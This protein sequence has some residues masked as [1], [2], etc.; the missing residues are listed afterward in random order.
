[1][2][3]FYKGLME[4]VKSEENKAIEELEEEYS[5]RKR[6]V[7]QKF[8]NRRRAV[9]AACPHDRTHTRGCFDYH[10]MVDWED[11]YCS[12]CGKLLSGV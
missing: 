3:D 5:A 1:M 4:E 2:S 6:E 12:D 7:F 10:T 8:G 11:T 9:Q